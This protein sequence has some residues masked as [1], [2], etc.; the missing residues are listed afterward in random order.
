MTLLWPWVWGLI[1]RWEFHQFVE[2][3]G[4]FRHQYDD[5][6]D[7]QCYDYPGQVGSC[8]DI[9]ISHGANCDNHKIEGRVERE[10]LIW[11]WHG[12]FESYAQVVEWIYD[13]CWDEHDGQYG[14]RN[15]YNFPSHLGGLTYDSVGGPVS[16]SLT[17]YR[18]RLSTLNRRYILST[19]NTLKTLTTPM[20][21]LKKSP[22]E[23]YPPG[24]YYTKTGNIVNKST[25]L[26]AW[27]KNL[28]YE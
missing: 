5:D 13:S 21:F 2:F 15:Y 24:T 3:T 26:E 18:N 25:I 22:A 23:L 6:D 1:Q 4:L 28:R 16:C 27:K 10:L 12:H 8:T 17:L 11:V 9:S 19:L 7:K 14:C 20:N